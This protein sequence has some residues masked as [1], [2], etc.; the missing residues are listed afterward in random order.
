MAGALIGAIAGGAAGGASEGMASAAQYQASKHERNISWKRQQAWELIAPSLRVAGLRQAGINPVLA[1]TEGFGRGATSVATGSP[2]QLPRFSGMGSQI[3]AAVSSAKEAR[4]MDT[5]L[6]IL[7]QHRQQEVEKTAQAVQDTEVK[8]RFGVGMARAQLAVEQQQFLNLVAEMGLTSA[9]QGQ[10]EQERMRTVTDRM[11]M[12][13]GIPSAQAME[14]LYTKYPEL[15][16]L[17]GILSGGIGTATGVGLGALGGWMARPDR[18]GR[19]S[20]QDFHKMVPLEQKGGR[21]VRPFGPAPQSHKPR[22]R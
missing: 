3:Q 9:R 6:A 19:S 10:S 20:N 15:R 4:A 12:E 1:A 2:G 16:Q 14:D 5:N 8:Q 13:M 11:L 21:A 7:E 18:P 22:R 17:Q